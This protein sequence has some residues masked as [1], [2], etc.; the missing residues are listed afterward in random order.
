MSE[1]KGT[2]GKLEIRGNHLFEKGTYNRVATISVQKYALLFNKAP[3]MLEML[4]KIVLMTD[5]CEGTFKDF[6]ERYNLEIKQLI[7]EATE[8]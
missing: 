2:K 4:Q 8:I 5:V 3:E 7:K 6:R 1:F